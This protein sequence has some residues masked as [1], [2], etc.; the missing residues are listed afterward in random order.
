M[1]IAV[2][3]AGAMGS[4]FG[5]ALAASGKEVWLVD[6]WQPHVEAI[7]ERGLFIEKQGQVR[8]VSVAATT[9][10]AEVGPVDLL[11]LF[12]KYGS[13]EAAMRGAGPLLTRETRVL[14]LQNGIG[15]VDLIAQF[16]PRERILAG[17]TTLTS[18]LKGPGFIEDT[19]DGPGE[20][21]C[22]PAAGEPDGF[23][24]AIERALCEAGIR[25]SLTPAV[26]RHIWLK[27]VINT[28]LNMMA[29]ITRLRVGDL[30]SHP[31]MRSLCLAVASEVARVAQ[32]EGVPLSEDEAVAH[33]R[34]V[35]AE[36]AQH[37]PSTLIDVLQGRK[38]EIECLNGAVARAAARH[39]IPVPV[40][41]MIVAL[42][43]TIESSYDRQVDRQSAGYAG[44]RR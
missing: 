36:A 42:I 21:Y 17:L 23:A 9:E 31:E 30:F 37:Q 4:L 40:T 10:P 26:T 7:R 16:V 24:Y 20:T 39:A 5:G 3:G 34:K 41:E 35:A 25:T 38:T 19:F 11:L 43:H 15:N 29:A 14:T 12:T 6:V 13:T 22:W 27:L 1:R 33:L 32:A 28:S 2:L 18:D 44:S 8:S